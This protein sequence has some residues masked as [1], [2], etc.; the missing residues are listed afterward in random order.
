MLFSQR[1]GF[2]P[3]KSILQIG[4]IDIDLMNRLWNIILEDFFHKFSDRENLYVHTHRS[5]ICRLVWKDFLNRRVDEM[6]RHAWGDTINSKNCII[7]FKVWFEKAKWY[8]VYDLIEFISGVKIS[9]VN[10]GSSQIQ[11]KFIQECNLALKKEVAG[12]RIIDGKVTQITSEEEIQT[13]EEATSQPGK[14]NLVSL[15]L[16]T[17][18]DLLA[19]RKNPDYRNSIK[20]SISAVESM[21]KMISNNSRDTLAGAIDKLKSK[22]KIHP[23]LEKGFKQIYGYT[24]DADGIRHGLMEIADCDF[25]DAKFMLVSC[26]AFI[27]YL[28][29][30]SNKAEISFV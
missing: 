28:I 16:K 27:N 4:T 10:S 12:Y 7:H 30:K 24:S 17:A 5:E 8:E 22:I 29:A 21:A 19:D 14:L 20:E 3:V 23:A 1:N 9:Y 6:P 18:L 25:E 13:I 26:S 15:H 11:E 2:K